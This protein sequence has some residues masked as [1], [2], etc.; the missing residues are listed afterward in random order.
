MGSGSVE[1]CLLGID[2]TVEVTSVIAGALNSARSLL[3]RLLIRH[4]MAA[5]Y[6]VT[7][8]LDSF[9]SEAILSISLMSAF[10]VEPVITVYANLF[11]PV[12]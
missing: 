7:P 8:A 6:Q 11:T 10:F 9:I 1:H 5:L 3:G 4:G 12:L 2:V